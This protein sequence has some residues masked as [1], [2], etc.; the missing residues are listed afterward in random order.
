MQKVALL[1]LICAFALAGCTSTPIAAPTPTPTPSPTI[2][3]GPVALPTEQAGTYY[4][5][6]V[7]QGNVANDVLRAAFA[8]GEPEF[9]Q[10]GEPDLTAVK[11]AAA[12]VTRVDRLLIEVLDD[13]Y[14]TWPA[15]VAEQI[16]YIRASM[17]AGLSTLNGY[18]NAA[19]FSDAYYATYP[20]QTA[21]QVSAPQEIRYQLELSADT[22]ASCVGYETRLDELHA[23][24]VDRNEYL[25]TFG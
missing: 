11:A 13:P 9:L 16:Q 18:A 25:A 14:F 2:D 7:C 5:S 21:E 22:T 19:R 15:G 17:V 3:P 1:V 8:A 12:E 10:G 23:E 4:L 24:M 6:A 20:E